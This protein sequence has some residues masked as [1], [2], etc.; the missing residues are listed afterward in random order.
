[1]RKALHNHSE[2]D[3]QKMEIYYSDIQEEL[4]MLKVLLMVA[5]IMST[6]VMLAIFGLFIYMKRSR[7]RL[8]ISNPSWCGG[9]GDDIMDLPVIY[10]NSKVN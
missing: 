1:M 6:I 2:Y 4:R 9:K 10:S 8:G 7:N 5:I 3:D